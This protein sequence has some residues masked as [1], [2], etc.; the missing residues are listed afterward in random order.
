[1]EADSVS[2]MLFLIHLDAVAYRGGFGVFK[3]PPEIPKF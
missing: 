1:M 3:P 2:E